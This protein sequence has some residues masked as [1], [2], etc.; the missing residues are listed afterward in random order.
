[1]RDAPA[2]LVE[3]APPGDHLF[4]G[5]MTALDQF[6]PRRGRHVVSEKSP[7]FLTKRDFFL[8]ESEIHRILL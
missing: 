6:L 5:E 3:D 2:L 7:H 4:L 1:M 8:A